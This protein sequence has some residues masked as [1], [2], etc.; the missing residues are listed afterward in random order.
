MGKNRNG[1]SI[2]HLSCYTVEGVLKT[3][4]TIR[5]GCM[6]CDHMHIF[7]TQQLE[8]MRDQHGPSYILNGRRFRCSQCQGWMR[9]NYQEGGM[10]WPLWSEKD[11]ERWDAKDRAR[12]PNP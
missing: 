6:K 12:S 10:W 1:E 3:G 8:A 5:A 2:P 4:R 9:L 7:T 11:G